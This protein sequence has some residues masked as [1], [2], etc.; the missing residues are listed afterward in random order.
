MLLERFRDV[1]TEK[2]NLN[3]LHQHPRQ[4]MNVYGRLIESGLNDVT[5]INMLL[6][7]VGHRHKLYEVTY[8]DIKVRIIS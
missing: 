1:E 8:D 3:T 2:L 5:Y 7:G 6:S 4:L